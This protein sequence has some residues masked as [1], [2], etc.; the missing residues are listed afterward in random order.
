MKQLWS[1]DSLGNRAEDSLVQLTFL[2]HFLETEKP[3]VAGKKKNMTYK[4]FLQTVNLIL[5]HNQLGH[6][7]YQFCQQLL[8]RLNVLT[9][10]LS[11]FVRLGRDEPVSTATT[12]AVIQDNAFKF[13]MQL[14]SH[15]KP[16]LKGDSQFLD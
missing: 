3:I 10:I 14:Y 4:V 2:R 13:L 1:E 9:Q 6:H 8:F 12:M 5:C 15:M 11:S 16:A 7:P